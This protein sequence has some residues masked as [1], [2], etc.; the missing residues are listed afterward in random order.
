MRTWAT[1][2]TTALLGVHL[3]KGPLYIHN[4]LTKTIQVSLCIQLDH[5]GYTAANS[6]TT[7]PLEIEGATSYW[8]TRNT[9]TQGTCYT[10]K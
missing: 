10:K 8:V 5:L 3:L 7:V 9:G 2:C 6:Y 4:W 1:R